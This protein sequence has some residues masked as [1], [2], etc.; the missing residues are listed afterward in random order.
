MREDTATYTYA[1]ADGKQFKTLGEVGGAAT[2][3]VL[4]VVG[5][6]AAGLT[7]PDWRENL[8]LA[9]HLSARMDALFPTLSRGV[10]VS[11][12]R[13]NQ[14]LAPG[15]LIVEIGSTGNTLREALRA[16]DFFAEAYASVISP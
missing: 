11:R 1:S 9:L 10:S 5:S 12:Y 7:H 4:L 3:Q 13:Y 14:Q 8:R 2:A 6:D 16:A 15:A